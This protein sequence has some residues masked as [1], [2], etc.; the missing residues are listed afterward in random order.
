MVHFSGR[1]AATAAVVA[2]VLVGLLASAAAA[3]VEGKI[4]WSGGNDVYV[5]NP[6]GSGFTRLTCYSTPPSFSATAQLAMWSSDGSKIAFQKYDYVAYGI[7][8]MNGDGSGQ[9]F[10]APGIEPTFSPDGSR[11]AFTGSDVTRLFVANSDGTGSVQNLGASGN[12][13]DPSWSPDGSRIAYTDVVSAIHI[14][15]SGNGTPI[16]T[17]PKPPGTNLILRTRWSTDGSKIAFMASSDNSQDSRDIWTVNSDGS[18]GYAQITADNVQDDYPGWTPAGRLFWNHNGTPIVADADGSNPQA[19]PWPAQ[20][21]GGLMFF[22]WSGDRAVNAAETDCSAAP[23]GALDPTNVDT[24]SGSVTLTTDTT[25]TGASADVPVQTALT[26]PQGLSGTASVAQRPV[27]TITPLTSYNFLGRELQIEAPQ[28]TVAAP[29]VLTFTID[30]TLLAQQGADYTTVQIVRTSIDGTSVVLPD[31]DPTT[32]AASPDPCVA[33]RSLSGD[34]AVVAVRTSHASTWDFA[35]HKPYQFSGFFQPVDNL[36]SSGNYVLNS[37]K[38]GSAVPV[39]FSLNGNQ[40]SS[41]LAA[42]S[43]ASGQIQCSS[44]A[45]VDAI[46]QTVAAN[47]SSLSFNG[48]NGQYNYVWKTDSRWAG[49]CRQLVIK[50]ADGTVH[51]ANFKFTK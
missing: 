50:L 44:S 51:R 35:I 37:T 5:S 48:A 34:D 40:G 23:S 15:D 46:E 13:S 16:V 7:Y 31:C 42:G 33:S 1:R 24:T 43:P 4:L 11:V 45:T 19:L 38:A 18:G 32:T 36:D 22:D 26:V 30:S 49:S 28:A 20:T 25:G 27:V 17:I 3:G 2:L 39:K 41:I 10:V 12:V 14:V 9:H 47:G 6:D 21:L 29:L 8:V